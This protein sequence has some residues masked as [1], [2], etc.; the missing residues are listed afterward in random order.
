MHKLPDAQSQKGDGH[1]CTKG[2]VILTDCQLCTCNG[3]TDISY[4]TFGMKSIYGTVMSDTSA[5]AP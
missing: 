2:I 1:I 5:A 4:Q 3:G